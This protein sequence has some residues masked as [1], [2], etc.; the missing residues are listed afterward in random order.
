M[1]LENHIQEGNE[2]LNFSEFGNY[3]KRK[4]ESKLQSIK[5]QVASGE[6]PLTSYTLI[7]RDAK[8]TEAQ[9]QILNN[10]IDKIQ[11][12]FNEEY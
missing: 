7:H 4:R 3:S 12:G 9:K 6:M 2:E 1:W 10:W 5:K 11:D 8:I